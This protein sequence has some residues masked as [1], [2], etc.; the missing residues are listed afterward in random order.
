MEVNGNE[1]SKLESLTKAASPNGFRSDHRS[2]RSL[3]IL[4]NI[5][6]L[7]TEYFSFP[8]HTLAAKESSSQLTHRDFRFPDL[9]H[10]AVGKVPGDAGQEEFHSEVHG[11]RLTES[12]HL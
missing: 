7:F 10:S 9:S 12:D 2:R 4:P 11:V 1:R 5:F 6:S 8:S 3:N